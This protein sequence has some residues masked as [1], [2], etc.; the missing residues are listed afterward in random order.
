MLTTTNFGF[1]KME[2]TDSPPDITV[3]NSNWDTVDTKLHRAVKF[4]TAGGTGTAITLSNVELSNGFCKSFIVLTNNG[5]AATSIN[6]KPLY[7]PGGT[8]APTLIA[9][10]AV[11]VWYDTAKTCFFIKASAEGTAVAA[12]VLAGTTFSNDSDTGIQGGMSNKGAVAI[13]PG[14]SNQTIQAGYHNGSGYVVG[15]S[16]LVSAN[17]KAG[18]NIFGVAGAFTSDGNLEASKMLAGQKGYSKG[19]EVNGNIETIQGDYNDQLQAN[20]LI[21]G[22]YSGG[23]TQ[24]LY[25]SKVELI[26]KYAKNIQFLRYPLA[27][28]L[29]NIG[30]KR[31]ASGTTKSQTTPQ[32]ATERYSSDTLMHGTGF[33]VYVN[34]LSFTPS[35]VS[36]FVPGSAVKYEVNYDVET[37]VR[38]DDGYGNNVSLLSNSAG[39]RC[40]N[41]GF[42]ALVVG[43]YVDVNWVAYE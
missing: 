22:A 38:T 28:V 8:T 36:L 3:P 33:P 40:I 4:E 14:T 30:A 15:D 43:M 9:G 12:N 25:M 20:N 21:V 41:G 39:I 27:E 42:S 5:G 2:L 6:S 34:G 18:A 17:I 29:V 11:T 1:K 32:F 13:T 31:Y 16:D 19:V 26:N 35:R 7:K 10:K 23:T 37:A 24:F